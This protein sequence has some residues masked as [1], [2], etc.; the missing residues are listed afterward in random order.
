MILKLT[1]LPIKAKVHQSIKI[2]VAPRYVSEIM[3]LFF[4]KNVHRRGN[5]FNM[6]LF[7]ES[8]EAWGESHF[9]SQNKR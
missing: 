4:S 8:L 6:P 7:A 3:P 9:E 5:Y 1:L 2:N